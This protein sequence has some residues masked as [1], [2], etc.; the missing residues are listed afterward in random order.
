[1]T[2]ARKPNFSDEVEDHN[3][4]RYINKA[5]ID[6]SKPKFLKKN[7]STSNL[8]ESSMSKSIAN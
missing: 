3:Y 2:N 6:I 4:D 1:M 8:R 7:F 5:T